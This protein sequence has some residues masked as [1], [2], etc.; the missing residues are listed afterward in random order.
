VGEE[1]QRQFKDSIDEQIR[2][3]QAKGCGCRVQTVGP[4]PE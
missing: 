4:A 2:L 1:R 3:L